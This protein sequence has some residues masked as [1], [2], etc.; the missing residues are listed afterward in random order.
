MP[1]IKA[2][3]NELKAAKLD[4][5]LF[6]DHHHRDPI[7]ANI[8]NLAGNGMATRRWFYF[9]PTRG[10]PR[11][12]VHRI[13]QGALEPLDGQRNVYSSWEELHKEGERLL[14]PSS[15]EPRAKKMIKLVVRPIYSP[16]PPERPPWLDDR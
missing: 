1:D 14:F 9:I 15:P 4:G 8:L 5:W 16:P 6:Y 3:Q 13:E 11:K 7:A 10:E 2:I 12:L